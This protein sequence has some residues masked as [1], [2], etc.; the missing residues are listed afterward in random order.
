MSTSPPI[1]VSCDL[2]TEPERYVMTDG[3]GV[4]SSFKVMNGSNNLLE[5]SNRSFA[6]RA[7]SVSHA[8][9]VSTMKVSTTKPSVLLS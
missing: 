1:V 7:K 8:M 2:D 5:Q 6:D 3:V 4:A 9:K